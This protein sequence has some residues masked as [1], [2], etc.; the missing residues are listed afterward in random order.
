MEAI[1]RNIYNSQLDLYDALLLECALDDIKDT[2]DGRKLMRYL[3]RRRRIINRIIN[4]L[5][6]V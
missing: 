6:K 3:N 4:L 5:E 2:D 1:M